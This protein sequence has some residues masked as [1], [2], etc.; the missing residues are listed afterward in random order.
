MTFV[1]D[2]RLLFAGLNLADFLKTLDFDLDLGTDL[3]LVVAARLT[4]FRGEV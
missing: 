1:A 2:R 3:A 4:F